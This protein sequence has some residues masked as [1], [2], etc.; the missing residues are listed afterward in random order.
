[1]RVN[2]LLVAAVALSAVVLLAA[3]VA[4]WGDT[5]H[6]LTAR[7]AMSLFEGNTGALMSQLVPEVG[8][9]ISN[10]NVSSW[11]DTIRCP[12]CPYPYTAPYHVGQK[13]TL[14][15]DGQLSCRSAACLS[16]H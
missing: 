2:C 4:A 14:A 10:V 5:G 13:T 15:R 12:T 8:G 7:I 1:M 3:R 6:T 11:P 16:C 9:N